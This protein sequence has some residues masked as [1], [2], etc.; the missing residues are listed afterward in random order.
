MKQNNFK[1]LHSYL[2]TW[3]VTQLDNNL[4]SKKNKLFDDLEI[5]DLEDKMQQLDKGTKFYAPLHTVM[6]K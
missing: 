4:F 1:I 3:A 2:E 6:P 5:I